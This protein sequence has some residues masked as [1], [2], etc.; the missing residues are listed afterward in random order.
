MGVVDPPLVSLYLGLLT[1]AS[2]LPPNTI[3]VRESPH[4]RGRVA[5]VDPVDDVNTHYALL[6][7]LEKEEES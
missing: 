1:C 4:F 2:S 5:N 3:F 7:N 6:V